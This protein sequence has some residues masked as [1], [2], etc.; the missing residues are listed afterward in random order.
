MPGSQTCYYILILVV[1]NY[2]LKEDDLSLG[3]TGSVKPWWTYKNDFEK[4]FTLFGLKNFK[5]D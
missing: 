1:A 3:A 5:T 4:S 2:V